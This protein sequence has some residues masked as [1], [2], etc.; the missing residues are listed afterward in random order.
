MADETVYSALP[1]E[2]KE[3]TKD[4]GWNSLCGMG[5]KS[6]ISQTWSIA[7]AAWCCESFS[8]FQLVLDAGEGI[9]DTMNFVVEDMD[10]SAFRKS[11][12]LEQTCVAAHVFLNGGWLIL[13]K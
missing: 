4:V 5:F 7:I 12:C 6:C 2:Q 11:M 9:L 10:S 13:V 1:Q 3:N 8:K